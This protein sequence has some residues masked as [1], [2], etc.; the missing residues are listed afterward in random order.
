MHIRRGLI[1]SLIL[2]WLCAGSVAAQE[3]L[4]PEEA[5]PVETRVDGA[6]QVSVI[7]DVTD[8]YYLYGGKFAF[9]TES[10]GFELG[11]PERPAGKIKQDEYF[12]EVEV[13]RG[14]VEVAI[15]VIRSADAGNELVLKTKSQG[16]ADAG[17]CY[18]PQRQSFDLTLPP[19]ASPSQSPASPADVLAAFGEEVGI[20]DEEEDGFIPVEKAFL[21]EAEAINGE[22]LRLAWRIAEGTYLYQEKI[23]VKLLEGQGV[24][25]GEIELPQ[26]KIK[27]DGV[28]PDGS[29]GDVAVYE[30][31]FEATL[32]L[33]HTAGGEKAISLEFGFQ[34]CAEI[35][36][37]YPPR[38][39]QLSFDLAAPTNV[40]EEAA[41]AQPADANASQ[42]S[43][44]APAASSGAPVAEQDRIADTLRGG[45]VWLILLTFFGFGALLS[46]TPC[47]F[48]MIPILS[49]IIA[50]QKNLT[51][52]RSFM[53]SLVY[54]L[55]M[56]A[57]YAGAGVLA[58][59]F[60]QNLQ[61]AFQDPWILSGFAVIF[62]LLALSMFGFY[63]LQ[64]PSSL[65]S[66]ISDV[67]NRQQGG[68]FTGVAV[69]GFLSALIVG[70]CVAP[71][72]AGALIYV[73]QTGDW[74]LGGAALFVMALGMGL[75]L[76]LIGA[77]AGKLLPRAGMWMEAIKAVFG[78]GLLAVAIV[79][80]ERI[81][82][83]AVSLVLWGALMVVSGV[84]MGALSQ[85]DEA[86]SGW[87]KLWKGLGLVLVIYGALM[88]IG[89]AA[90]GKDTVQPLRGIG[91][92]GVAGAGGP[93]H[94]EFKR[95]K[96]VEDL[97]REVA[98]A[99][100]PVMLDFYADWCVSCKEMER[101]TFSD[102]E[103]IKTLESYLV[104]QA[105][106]TAD[107]EQD[108]ALLQGRFGLPG[109]PAI[110]FYG[111]DGVERSNYRVVGF[112]DAETF[113]AHAREAV[114]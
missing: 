65:Q 9:S 18:P 104:L 54:V 84:Y 25:L 28:R 14:R 73:G 114:R 69:M 46:L 64:L 59:V 82:P 78:V 56:A 22:S 67:S 11:E 32:P 98:N 105:D 93:A 48:P 91:F 38:K 55:A 74:M 76:L 81:L 58:A 6:G 62:V 68:S 51:T 30:H 60:G 44:A 21:F 107:D 29:F 92:G 106:V 61:A 33:I 90:G 47:V 112:M 113:A 41:G 108:R 111:A 52:R 50:G 37:C 27:K 97:Q 35:G 99:N 13:L 89:A 40:A 4:P 80:L 10:P 36:I 3:F 23:E 24:R 71:P 100:R 70:P 66:R 15:P 17:L 95:I 20:D 2:F 57:T 5:F 77:S 85:L 16:C 109:P 19:Q 86:V 102:P 103:V 31:D 87:R 7:W 110:I 43:E 79:L 12:G 63:E 26:P 88:L 94:V 53:L 72:L 39:V 96:T 101:Y 45:S 42:A 83:P 34:G 1:F 49:G 75:P 8:G